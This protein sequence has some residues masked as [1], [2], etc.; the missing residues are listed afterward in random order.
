MNFGP[1]PPLRAK[2]LLT[3]LALAS[4]PS[5]RAARPPRAA[6]FFV[7]NFAT[8]SGCSCDGCCSVSFMPPFTM[9]RWFSRMNIRPVAW[10]EANQER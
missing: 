10:R 2:F 5:S 6:H 3:C 8:A 4:G 7:L 9:P 1:T